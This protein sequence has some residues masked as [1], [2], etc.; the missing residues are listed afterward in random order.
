MKKM[1][2]FW[3]GL[4]PLSRR[5]LFVFFAAILITSCALPRHAIDLQTVMDNAPRQDENGP[6]GYRCTMGAH[7][8]DSTSYVENTPQAIRAARN[9]PKYAF[10]EFDVQYSADN[11]A[12]VFHDANLLRVFGHIKKVSDSTYEELCTLSDNQIATY[13]QIMNLTDGKPVNIEIKSQGDEAEDRQ[14]IDYVVADVKTRKIENR[15]LISSISEEAV[16]YVKQQYPEIAAGQIFWLKAST[17]LPFDFLT[18]GL[19][20]QINE[21]KADYILLHRVNLLNLKD[22]I[23]LKPQDK[24]LVFWDFGDTMYVV[25]KDLSDRMWGDSGTQTLF[26]WLHYKISRKHFDR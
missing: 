19:Y 16:K 20:R 25:H 10:I 18:E 15:V 26:D 23:K 12:V 11:Q 14:L 2:L 3:R 13:E 1:V 5:A 22:L 24:T 6:F 4:R 21:S 9:N 7:R 17:Y 8:G